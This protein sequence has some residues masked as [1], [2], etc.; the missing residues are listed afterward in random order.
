MQRDEHV[1]EVLT[2]AGP[3]CGARA[4][5]ASL[6]ASTRPSTNPIT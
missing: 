6:S 2:G 1:D 5:P 4:S 3:A